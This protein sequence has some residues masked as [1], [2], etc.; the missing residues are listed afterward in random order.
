MP[1]VDSQLEK[2]SLEISKHYEQ[3]TDTEIDLLVCKLYGLGKEETDYII[4]Q[5]TI[6]LS[7]KSYGEI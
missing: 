3:G 5:W 7:Q 6:F 1:P 4:G 2:L